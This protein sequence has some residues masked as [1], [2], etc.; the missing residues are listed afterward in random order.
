[1]AYR[2]IVFGFGKLNS[3]MGARRGGGGAEGPK[4]VKSRIIVDQRLETTNL[5]VDCQ[6][7]VSKSTDTSDHERRKT[8]NGL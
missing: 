8:T 6:R 4:V 2:G 3:T 7:I 5:I 1:M